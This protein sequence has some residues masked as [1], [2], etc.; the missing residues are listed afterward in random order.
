MRL[1]EYII[2]S[3][4]LF[5]FYFIFFSLEGSHGTSLCVLERHLLKDTKMGMARCLALPLIY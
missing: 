3:E 2:Q 1:R 4:F 5:L